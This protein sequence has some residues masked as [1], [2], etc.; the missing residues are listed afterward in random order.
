MSDSDFEADFRLVLEAAMTPPPDATGWTTES[1]MR[2]TGLS[3]E[4]VEAVERFINESPSS[5]L[6]RDIAEAGEGESLTI[7]LPAD[8]TAGQRRDGNDFFPV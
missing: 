2:R 4:R 5:Q 1:F 7:G 6:V 3:R 8:P